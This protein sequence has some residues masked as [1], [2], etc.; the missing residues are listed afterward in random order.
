MKERNEIISILEKESSKRTESDLNKCIPYM[1]EV[2]FFKEL[3]IKEVDYPVI[4]EALNLE[5]F[6]PDLVVMNW[7]D[8]GDKFYITILSVSHHAKR[9]HSRANVSWRIHK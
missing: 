1:M 8:L 5:V 7:G 3:E 6:E 9:K 4:I 2:K